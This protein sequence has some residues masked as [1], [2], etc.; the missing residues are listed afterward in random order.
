MVDGRAVP[1]S[2]D[3]I[4]GKVY[5]VGGID[6]SGTTTSHGYV[7]DPVQNTWTSIAAMPAVREKP[8]VAAMNGKLYVTGGWDASGTTPV[9]ETD[10]YDPSANSWSTV[11]PNP[12][13]TAAPG[14]A[15]A[16]GKIYFVGGCLDAQC[17]PS[18]TV[19]VY[20][21]ATDSWRSAAPYP[22]PVSWE[23]CGAI[24]GKVYCAGGLAGRTTYSNGYV[25]DP[26]SDSWSPIASMPIDLWGSA[27]GAANGLLVV[28]SGVT[29]GGSTLTNQGYAYDPT[30]DSWTAIPNAQ[31]PRVRGGGSCGFYKIGGLGGS[32]FTPDSEVLSGLTEC[33]GTVAIP[34]LADSPASATLQPGQS[35]AVTVT[36]S[37]TTADQVTQP[38]TLTGQL[39]VEQDTP[40]D[41]SPVD[42]TMNVAPP[43]GWGK[44]AGTLSGEDC[45]Q[46]TAPLRGVVFADG[47]KGYSFTLPTGND[48]RYAFWA[49]SGAS[50]FTMTASA[51]GWIP[52]T[53]V[54][55]IKGGKTTTV[56]FTLR[57]TS[58]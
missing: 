11:S 33:G 56:N 28:S 30:D 15:A 4:G 1:N 13:P 58:C 42:V 29:A 8:G 35:V 45:S 57:P 48:G 41:V 20:D 2:A 51:N 34:W 25:Y 54:V 52:Q 53:R 10:V 50:P 23:S 7:Y 19:E 39:G 24:T 14:V 17:T 32:G 43:K 9:A 55:S 31:F 12:Q 49:P 18:T 16:N 36:L 3:I 21:P 44:I 38:G 47:K 37:A 26:G 27:Y 5:S 46:T 6:S 22:Q 40:Y